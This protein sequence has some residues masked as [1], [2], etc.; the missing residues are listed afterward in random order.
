MVCTEATAL[1]TAG[2]LSDKISSNHEA[3]VATNKTE[4]KTTILD[5][6]QQQSDR[7]EDEQ[8][9]L[10]FTENTPSV[11]SP[12]TTSINEADSYDSRS[13]YLTNFLLV[14]N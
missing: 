5:Q 7:V 3:G 13:P 2:T 6:Q 1:P 8:I 12:Q 9:N 10:N 11:A 4:I 14:I